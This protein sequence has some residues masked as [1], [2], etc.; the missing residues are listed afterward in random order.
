M[1]DQLNNQIFKNYILIPILFHIKKS[2]LV[3]TTNEKYQTIK[4]WKKAQDDHFMT[5]LEMDKIFLNKT[6]NHKRRM[7]LNWTTLKLRTSHQKIKTAKQGTP[8]AVSV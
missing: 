3:D 4:L 6:K 2:T 7:R 1:L 5:L 8:L